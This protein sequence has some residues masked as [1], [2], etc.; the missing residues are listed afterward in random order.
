LILACSCLTIQYA[1]CIDL[2]SN[3][4]DGI[5][6]GD[7]YR[8]LEPNE[9]GIFKVGISSYFTKYWLVNYQKDIDKESNIK[10]KFYA[11]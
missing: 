1:A 6:C 5:F 8:Y 7:F 11:R 4:A 9:D 2:A 10:N 3:D